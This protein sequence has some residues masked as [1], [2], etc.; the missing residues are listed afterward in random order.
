VRGGRFSTSSS[1]RRSASANRKPRVADMVDLFCLLLSPA[2]GDELQG[3]KKGIV[4]LAE[5][6]IVNKGRRAAARHRAAH[7]GRLSRRATPDPPAIDLLDARG[8]RGVGPAPAP[9]WIRFGTRSG[10]TRT[11]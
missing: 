3:I 4:E 5:L 7:R 1:W 11:Y 8:D 10:G 9:G 2:S 6:I